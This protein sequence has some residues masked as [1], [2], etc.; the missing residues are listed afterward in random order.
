MTDFPVSEADEEIQYGSR[1]PLALVGSV[2]PKK[3]EMPV[4]AMIPSP[5]RC[6]RMKILC[7]STGSWVGIM[8]RHIKNAGEGVDNKRIPTQM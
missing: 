1:S 4:H 6:C 8:K 3:K 2:W 7:E 5:Y